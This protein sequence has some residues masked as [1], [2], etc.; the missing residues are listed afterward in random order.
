MIRHCTPWKFSRSPTAA[1]LDGVSF[2]QRI[3][4]KGGP[5]RTWAFA[6][7][8]SKS[9]VRTHRYKLY[10][11]GPFFAPTQDPSEKRPIDADKLDKSAAKE[12]QF[13]EKTLRT[14]GT[15]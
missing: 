8:R 15:P 9:W 14:L 12:H 11:D 6:E 7:H 4:G 1:G 2:A 5:S 10:A 3:L 13:L